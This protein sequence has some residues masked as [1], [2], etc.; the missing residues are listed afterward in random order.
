LSGKKEYFLDLLFFNRKL[1]SLVAIDLKNGEFEPEYIGKMNFYLGLLD[2]QARMPD[3]NPS[4]GLILCADKNNVDVEIALRDVNKP[5]GV[6]DYKM[7]FPTE[8]LKKMIRKEL[9]A[10]DAHDR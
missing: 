5:I 10:T 8:Q 1:K 2:K 3:E 7:A 4:V 6:A 9:K